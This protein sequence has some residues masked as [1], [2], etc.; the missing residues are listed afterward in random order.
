MPTPLV[1]TSVT[2]PTMEELRRRRDAAARSA[3]LVELRLDSVERPDVAGALEGR[4]GPVVVTCR[5]AWEGGAFEGAEEE[6]LGLLTEAVRRGADYV[7]VEW[8]AGFEDLVRSQGGRGIVMSWHRFDGLPPDLEAAYRAMRATGAEIVKIAV[9]TNG[10]ADLVPLAALARNGWGSHVVIGMGPSGVLS[11]ILPRRFGSAWTYAG[12]GVAPGQVAVERLVDEFRLRETTAEATIYGLLG[13]PVG[14]SLSPA[15][16]NAAFRHLGLDA[17]YVPLEAASFEDFR[18]FATGFP[19]AGC[20]VTAP[21]KTE[22]FAFADRHEGDA[23]WLGAVNTLG[24]EDATWIGMNA[25][26]DGFLEPLVDRLDVS[27]VRAA[28][29]GAGGAARAVAGGL[30]RQGAQVTLHARSIDRARAVAEAT[31]GTAGPWPV[32]AGSWD[33]LVNATPVGTWPGP[34]ESPVPA[35][36]LTGRLVYDLVYNPEETRLLAEASAAGCETLGGLSML[37]AQARRQSR[38]WTG[39]DVPAAILER[40]ARGSRDAMAATTTGSRR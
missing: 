9:T 39:C 32:P 40:A 12:E 27:G 22:A 31:G 28:V 36:S 25:D 4:R 20:S 26:V 2:A 3:D 24:R 11:R 21:F 15:M 33:L 1:C 23:A 6:R 37:V 14:H 34:Q 19:L 7:D 13:R 35:A 29:L 8:K 38:W 16:H 10:L 18:R 5:P 17:V 30:V